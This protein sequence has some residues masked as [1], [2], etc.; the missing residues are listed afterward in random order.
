MFD[1]FYP[2][3]R[4]NFFFLGGV[5]LGKSFADGSSAYFKERYNEGSGENYVTEYF[6][7]SGR[8]I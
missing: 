8:I 2:L 5:V 4:T 7:P 3:A 6:F 1:L